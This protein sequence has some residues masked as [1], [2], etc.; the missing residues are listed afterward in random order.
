MKHETIIISIAI[1]R[2]LPEPAIPG[3]TWPGRARP[4]LFW[5]YH[6]IQT[7]GFEARPSPKPM[8]STIDTCRFLAGRSAL[9]E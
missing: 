9:L 5:V 8:T 6:A 7:L 2:I 3:P 4:G 1:M